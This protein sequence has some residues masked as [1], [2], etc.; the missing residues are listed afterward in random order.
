MCAKVCEV[1]FRG[2]TGTIYIILF[3]F[4]K[5]QMLYMLMS[6]KLTTEIMALNYY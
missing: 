2:D 5:S 4:H 3:F 6:Q 1:N